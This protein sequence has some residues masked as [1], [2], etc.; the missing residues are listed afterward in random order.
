[1]SKLKLTSALLEQKRREIGGEING[2]PLMSIAAW[3][4]YLG[5]KSRA[6]STARSLHAQY[7]Q[8][9]N[10]LDDEVKPNGEKYSV[11][12]DVLMRVA[13]KIGMDET[14]EK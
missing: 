5:F 10:F 14:T 9:C 7:G 3:A 13:R 12:T 6:K 11:S 8:L 1:M 4:K 2:K